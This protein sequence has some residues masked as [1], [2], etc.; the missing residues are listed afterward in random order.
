[1]TD[2]LSAY[3]AYL[4]YFLVHVFCF[5]VCALKPPVGCEC[6]FPHFV[7]RQQSC[8]EYAVTLWEDCLLLDESGTWIQIFQTL[9]LV[10]PP[11]EMPTYFAQDKAHEQKCSWNTARRQEEKLCQRTSAEW[12]PSPRV[13]HAPAVPDSLPSVLANF[14]P[15]TAMVVL[16]VKGKTEKDVF[17]FETTTPSPPPLEVHD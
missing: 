6:L 10:L 14:P 2:R 16:K 5:V 4:V 15:A 7:A 11:S 1:M 12:F 3:F 8:D 17:L 13:G 9:A